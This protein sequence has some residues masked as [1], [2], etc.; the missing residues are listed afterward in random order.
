MGS[1]VPGW[2]PVSRSGP[3]GRDVSSLI[4]D[5]PVQSGDK[6]DL[7][8]WMQRLCRAA[9][10]ELSALGVGMNV[11]S[12][13]GAVSV[14]AASSPESEVIEQLQFTLG[15]G[16]CMDAYAFGQPVLTPDLSEGVG[17]RWPGY[18][19]AAQD[20]GVRAVFAFPLQIGAARLGAMDVCR[21]HPGSLSTPD[22][23]QAL[24]FAKAAMLAL[25]NA[26]EHTGGDERSVLGRVMEDSILVYQAQG[27]VQ[28]Q[29]GVSLAEAM[30]RLRAYAFAHDRALNAVAA[31]VVARRV[32]FE[33][34]C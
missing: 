29:L 8:G 22:L 19:S 4:G 32:V 16:P 7:G 20:H 28:V 25:V 30:A 9:T 31:D 18:S 10:R 12:P 26:Q 13:H 3:T 17:R 27:M 2:Q 33:P 15:E 21:D 14:L 6:P 23:H 11:M 5:E 1:A 34:G 24:A